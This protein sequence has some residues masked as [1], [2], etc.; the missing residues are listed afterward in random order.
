MR[1]TLL[2][3]VLLLACESKPQK[4]PDSSSDTKKNDSIKSQSAPSI[5]RSQNEWDTL[6]TSMNN[7]AIV[8]G[9]SITG[10]ISYVAIKFE[11]R[12]RFSDFSTDTLHQQQ[13]KPLNFN[14]NRGSKR[15]K[16]VIR[17]AYKKEVVNFAGHYC[18]IEWGCGSPCQQSVLVDVMTGK[19]YDGPSAGLGYEFQNNSRMLIVNPVSSQET[20]VF[21][22]KP[23]YFL[24]CPYC[25]PEIH[26]WN[27][28]LKKFE[29][30]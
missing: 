21:H 11:P 7:D 16:T 29:Q 8:F 14:S 10:E 18:F 17:N 6:Y 4:Q 9:D 30:R 2:C 23:N 3:L 19:I 5:K 15:F 26:I 22:P 1:P 27:E 24:D 13:V 28:I 12:V 20:D 25:K